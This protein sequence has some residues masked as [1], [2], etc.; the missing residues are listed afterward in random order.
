LISSQLFSVIA[1]NET[2]ETYG[3][4]SSAAAVRVIYVVSEYNKKGQLEHVLA[5]LSLQKYAI[6][7]FCSSRSQVIMALM[8][9]KSS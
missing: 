4:D 8:K 2:V 3:L 7:E 5:E 1:V 9:L 6:N